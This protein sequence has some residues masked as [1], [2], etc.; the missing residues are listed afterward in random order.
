MAQKA[1]RFGVVDGHGHRASSWKCWVETGRGK[2]DVYL[3]CRRLGGVLKASFHE[4]GSWHVAFDSKKFLGLFE[5]TDRPPSRFAM[6]WSRPP[7][8]APGVLLPCRVLVP[9]YAPTVSESAYDDTVKL[10]QTAPHGEALEFAVV[11]TSAA[12]PVSDW[13]TR[14]SMNTDL[15]GSVSLNSGNRVWVVYHLIDWTDPPAVTGRPRFGK[16]RTAPDLSGTGIRALAWRQE[17]DGSIAFLDAPVTVRQN[18]SD[19]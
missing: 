14:R 6:Q 3:T 19:S 18:R 9:W 1:I 17:A 13:P 4:S 2:N 16:G 7:E 15:V 12:T 10:I 5:D 8:L 11:I